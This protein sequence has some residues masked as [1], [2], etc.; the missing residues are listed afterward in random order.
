[1]R[2]PVFSNLARLHHLIVSIA[3]AL[4]ITTTAGAQ[5]ITGTIEGTVVDANQA[6]VPGATVELKHVETNTT[7]T[8]TTDDEGRFNAP[9]L[10]PGKY[11]VTV[12]RQ[13]FAT[14]NDPNVNLTVGQTASLNFKLTGSEVAGTVTVTSTQ[15][16][17]VARTEV[18]T[19]L[20]ETA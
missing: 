16:V 13:G 19:T 10:Q 14:A 4:L 11:S 9:L 1:M 5:I 15:T 20:N 17:D 18:S 7:R 6:V 12:S 3:F 8:V 2:P